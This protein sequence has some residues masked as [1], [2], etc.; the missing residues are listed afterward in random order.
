CFPTLVSIQLGK[1]HQ[2]PGPPIRPL[3]R[4]AQR[5]CEIADFAFC[6]HRGQL[7]IEQLLDLP[8]FAQL[9]KESQQSR[10]QPVS[11]DA[12]MPV[13]AAEENR[14]QLPWRSQICAL[15]KYMIEL[16]WVL[17][18]YVRQ[19]GSCKLLG[20]ARCQGCTTL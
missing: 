19:R 5:A 7:S 20:R 1:K 9:R 6:F 12:R 18:S 16:V 10:Q 2:K 14:M 15:V 17:A 8:C 3:E 13:E 4:R 11:V